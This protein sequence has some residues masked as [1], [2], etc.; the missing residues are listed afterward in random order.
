MY[1]LCGFLMDGTAR[2]NDTSLPEYERLRELDK[3]CYCT[4]DM[5][6]IDGVY[7]KYCDDYL[8]NLKTAFSDG[9]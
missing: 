8:G 1:I 3:V 5:N 7:C 4:D 2:Y 6:N 9:D